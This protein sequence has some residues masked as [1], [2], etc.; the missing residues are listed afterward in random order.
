MSALPAPD[1][2]YWSKHTT[3]VITW[4]G[5][6]SGVT[7]MGKWR[8]NA[9]GSLAV[10]YTRDSLALAVATLREIER[11][12]AAAPAVVTPPEPVAPMPQPARLVFGRMS[13]RDGR[14]L[15]RLAQPAAAARPPGGEQQEGLL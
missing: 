8:R 11:L 12:R 9:D 2:G 14:Q 13:A 15:A 3:I 6:L 10:E 7:A 5:D 1:Q 4:P